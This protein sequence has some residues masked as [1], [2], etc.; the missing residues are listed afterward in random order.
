MDNTCAICLSTMPT[1][2]HG[3]QHCHTLSKCGHA[4]HF[5]C[6]S[7]SVQSCGSSCPLCRSSIVDKEFELLSNIGSY[8]YKDLTNRYVERS[9]SLLINKY[10]NILTESFFKESIIKHINSQSD[11]SIYKKNWLINNM[12]REINDC[13]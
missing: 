7:Q 12:N 5:D 10:I 1:F 9:F 2:G 13:I 8:L 4:F 6:I 3:T 11:I